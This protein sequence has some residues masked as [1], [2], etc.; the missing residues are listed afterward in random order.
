MDFKIDGVFDSLSYRYIPYN[1]R[2][3][4]KTVYNLVS[5]NFFNNMHNLYKIQPQIRIDLYNNELDRINR[6]NELNENFKKSIKSIKPKTK[7][8]IEYSIKIKNRL[9]NS[10]KLIESFINANKSIISDKINDKKIPIKHIKE[11]FGNCYNYDKISKKGYI[12]ILSIIL[13]IVI[14]NISFE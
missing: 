5:K 9:T 1:L 6:L 7:N 11:D 3:E 8:D 13:L 2:N 14:F 10:C 4:W 12:I